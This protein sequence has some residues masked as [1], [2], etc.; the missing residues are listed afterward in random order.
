M[1]AKMV[2]KGKRI[3]KEFPECCYILK[4]QKIIK[5]RYDPTEPTFKKITYFCNKMQKQ[6]KKSYCKGCM[7]YKPLM[8]NNHLPNMPKT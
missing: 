3:Y 6:I 5:S 7:L 8:T 4:R 1:E 2:R